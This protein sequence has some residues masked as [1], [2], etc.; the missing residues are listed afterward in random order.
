MVTR[1]ILA[2]ALA[3]SLCTAHAGVDPAAMDRKA[4]PCTDFY[5]YVNGTWQRSDA[6]RIPP[7]LSVWGSFAQLLRAS[8]DTLR[9]AFDE[10]LKAPSPSEASKRRVV[11]YYRSGMDEAAIARAGIGPLAPMLAKIAALDGAAGLPRLL[12][13][14][15]AADIEPG[16]AFDVRP[17]AK[18]S[19]R[20]LAVVSQGG[21][22]LPDR[23]Y[24]FLDD[25]RSRSIR[26]AYRKHI[27][28]VL[29]IDGPAEA[30]QADAARI[31]DLETEL[32]RASMTVVERRDVD[33]TYN[34]MTVAELERAAP[35]FAW[36]EYFEAL[37]ARSLD[38]LNAS[39]PAYLKRFAA[40]AA[41]RPVADWRAYARW[42]LLRAASDKLQPAYESRFFDFYE[43]TLR[44][45]KEPPTRHKRLVLVIGGRYGGEP[46]A[47]GLGHV[48]VDR[49]FPPEAKAR[50]L[51]MV[52]D[53]K[54]ALRDRLKAADWMT[55]ETRKVSL[56]KLDA[57]RPRIGYP[58][59]WRDLSTAETSAGKP[60][61]E[62]WLAANRFKHRRDLS[63]IG[64][65]VDRDEWITSPHIVNAFYNASRNEIVFPAAILQPPF[66]DL[67]ADDAANYGGIGMVI[68]HEI[69]H[70]F[71]DRGRR[72]DKDGNLRDWWSEEDSLRY[73][74]RAKRVETQYNGYS[75]VDGIKVNGA[76]TLGE[77]ISDIGGAHIA[78]VALQKAQ[79]RKPLGSIDGFT[80]G[81][82]FFLSMGNI[83]RTSL[84]PEYERLLLRTDSHSL[85]PLRVRGI[86][87]N[88]PEFARAF[89]CDAGK[90]LLSE[91]ERGNIW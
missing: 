38:Q 76:L 60:F 77:N 83:W 13:E 42:Q 50:M 79:A 86:L 19:T 88:M 10:A 24:Y 30:A 25:E 48:Y 55:E 54:E 80:P 14:L 17:D 72:F 6:A 15:H 37:G 2:A 36:R 34:R 57:M 28:E 58:D 16:F 1:R 78:W 27:A 84:R 71:D 11:D 89:S 44:G 49:A 33:K 22:G 87:A 90:V 75:G 7:D 46:L 23:D 21:L 8:D 41:E 73:K 9:A 53:I 74:E 18:D 20:Y 70:G 59:K 4:D 43:R 26:E 67:K 3:T 31:F 39:Q 68:G 63:R 66:F 69:T 81:Q 65:E 29:A 61:V 85:A 32:A 52:Q 47:E 51:V 12:G 40:L 64:K 91:S 5:G 62:N 82:R 35:G 45:Q 56:Q